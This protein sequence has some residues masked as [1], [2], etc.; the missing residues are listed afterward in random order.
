MLVDGLIGVIIL[1][2][3]LAISISFHEFIHG[4]VADLLGDPTA[5]LSGRL[6]LNP[7]AHIDPIMTILLPGLLLLSGSPIIFAAAKPVPFNP[8]AF[9]NR[10]LGSFLTAIAGPA[11]NFFLALISAVPLY[12]M[13]GV[14]S[15][16]LG[17]VIFQTFFIEMVIINIVL[18]VINLVPIPPLDGS[19]VLYFFLPEEVIFTFERM[20]YFGIFFFFL[21]LMVFGPH[22]FSIVSFLTK[23]FLPAGIFVRFPI[24]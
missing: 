20:A 18:G 21:F 16:S 17:F 4:Y 3:A 7:L 1:I 19:K 2:T 22:L 12:L 8:L 24:F 6:T 9:S 13:S 15:S 11:S 23:L 10:K 5:R 14:A